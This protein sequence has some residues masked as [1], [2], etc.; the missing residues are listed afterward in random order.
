MLTFFTSLY[1]SVSKDDKDTKATASSAPT[2][3]AP[4]SLEE[5]KTS[6]EVKAEQDLNK[7]NDEHQNDNIIVRF[8]DKAGQQKPLNEQEKTFKR[9]YLMQSVF[10]KTIL[11]GNKD[12]KELQINS[13]SLGIPLLALFSL[14]QFLPINTPVAHNAIKEI[15]KQY[16]PSTVLKAAHYLD[17][18]K[19]IDLTIPAI[20]DEFLANYTNDKWY[21]QWLEDMKGPLK[22]FEKQIV[23]AIMRKANCLNFQGLPADLGQR[24]SLFYKYN[25]GKYFV[26]PH[27]EYVAVHVIF[28]PS[29]RGFKT[30]AK[31]IIWKLDSVNSKEPIAEIGISDSE[32][33]EVSW[34][35]DNTAIYIDG[36]LF[37]I[38]SQEKKKVGGVFFK[39][40]GNNYAQSNKIYDANG[41]ILKTLP[42][43][44]EVIGGNSSKIAVIDIYRNL[45]IIDMQTNTEIPFMLANPSG[46]TVTFSQD[47]RFFATF[48]Q[49]DISIFNTSNGKLIKKIKGNHYQWIPHTSMLAVTE[50]KG[51]YVEFQI[52]NVTESDVTL[53][54]IFKVTNV[55]G[56][57][58]YWLPNNTLAFQ[59][60]DNI[61]LFDLQNRT[62]P[63]PLDQL[64]DKIKQCMQQQAMPETENKQSKE[65]SSASSTQTKDEKI[66]K[67]DKQEKSAPAKK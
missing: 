3:A 43:V 8:T 51:T 45:F 31:I 49:G 61:P 14:L 47:S 59:R 19:L 46:V 15:I 40:L 66:S 29:M 20:A 23:L 37:N 64:R 10:F 52:Y 17:I 39:W 55:L 7:Y 6:K 32:V 41:A 11:E 65:T 22:N 57:K 60:T 33:R 13:Q 36:I 56:S 53:I 4:I 30:P 25:A 54:K 28:D 24:D 2:P 35:Q 48:L 42:D 58:F 26:S 38:H 21:S 27:G 16:G 18:Q 62:Q 67:D 63:F 50:L 34:N 44:Y 1:C 9:K 12:E 5:V